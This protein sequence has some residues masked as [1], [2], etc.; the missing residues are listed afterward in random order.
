MKLHPDC[1]KIKD[2]RIE[3]LLGARMSIEAFVMTLGPNDPFALVGDTVYALSEDEFFST[4]QLRHLMDEQEQAFQ[5]VMGLEDLS[6]MSEEDQKLVN[7]VKKELP[8]CPVCKYKRYKQSIFKLVHKYN[9]P[10]TFSLKSIIDD[11]VYPDTTGEVASTVTA[12]LDRPYVFTQPDR[13]PCMDC[14]E[15]HVSQAYILACESQMGYPEHRILMCGHLAEAID[16]TPKEFP[17]LR[18]SIGLCMAMTMR[19]GEAYMPI[20]P[21]LTEIQLF[22]EKL[23]T[24][25][26]DTREENPAVTDTI[27]MNDDI[28]QELDNLSDAEKRQI[29]SRCGLIQDSILEYKNSRREL[30]RIL[31]EGEMAILADSVVYQAPLFAN[32]IRNLRLM[33]VAD[34]SL[35][36]DSGYMLQDVIAYLNVKSI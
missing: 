25:P 33:F 12:I 15:K 20:Y 10:V 36:A 4:R 34:P 16:E 17:E 30:N 1:Y 22:R 31:F 28:K 27:D 7:K 29:L 3:M 11:V 14:V 32:M 8:T 5:Y 2:H 9:L 35:A 26:I 13:K 19:T 21:L 23:G 18:A 6:F 24:A